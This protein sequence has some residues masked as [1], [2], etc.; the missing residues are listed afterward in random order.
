MIHILT[1]ETTDINQLV[2]NSHSTV[3]CTKEENDQWPITSGMRVKEEIH[4]QDNND[5]RKHGLKS[6][7][8]MTTVSEDQKEGKKDSTLNSKR[9]ESS[10]HDNETMDDTS[11]YI[12]HIENCCFAWAG[13]AEQRSVYRVPRPTHPRRVNQSIQKEKCWRKGT[14]TLQNDAASTETTAK[15]HALVGKKQLKKGGLKAKENHQ[16]QHENGKEG[17]MG[18]NQ[19]LH[20]PRLR[21]KHGELV[22]VVGNVGS[23]KSTL[24]SSIL[25]ETVLV[26]SNGFTGRDTN[27]PWF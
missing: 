21:I 1:K 22:L 18:F 6:E 13:N 26:G 3:S 10:R 25:R 7:E 4:R 19:F 23:G 17:G 5:N 14:G 20:I 16:T 12:V 15:S 27:H 2:S 11:P 8:M 9:M 24:L